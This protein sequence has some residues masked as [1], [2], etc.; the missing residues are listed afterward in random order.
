MKETNI[1]LYNSCLDKHFKSE[2]FIT[3]I[4]LISFFIAFISV[5]AFTQVSITHFSG[6]LPTEGTV[7]RFDVDHNQQDLNAGYMTFEQVNK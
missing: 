7:A 1:T 2:P 3:R 4:G 6:T 5:A